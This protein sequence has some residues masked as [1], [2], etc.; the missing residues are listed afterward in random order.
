MY[1]GAPTLR[2]CRF[3]QEGDRQLARGWR[4]IEFSH[5]TRCIRIFGTTERCA[6]VRI[7]HCKR[8]EEKEGKDGGR[9]GGEGKIGSCR[10]HVKERL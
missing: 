3:A 1:G 10:E 9:G 2:R 5:R 8:G 7:S 6:V 4:K